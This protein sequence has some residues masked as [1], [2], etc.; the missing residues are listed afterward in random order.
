[1]NGSTASKT[2]DN[3]DMAKTTKKPFCVFFCFFFFNLVL[4][5]EGTYL[6]TFLNASYHNGIALD[7]KAHLTFF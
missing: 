2:M 1:M 4:A 7:V 3:R 5:V 6:I